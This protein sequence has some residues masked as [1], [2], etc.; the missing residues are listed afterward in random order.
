MPYSYK[1]LAV[2]QM[3]IAKANVVIFCGKARGHSANLLIF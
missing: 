1:T 2:R 3:G